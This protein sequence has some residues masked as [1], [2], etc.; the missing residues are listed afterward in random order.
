MIATAYKFIRYDKPK[1]IGVVIGIIISTFL[2]GQQVGILTFLTTLMG[3]LVSNSDTGKA[4][5]WITD[6]ITINANELAK[7]DG[8]VAREVRSIEGVE[9]AYPI[10]VTP[11]V[12]S[13]SNGKTAPVTII[14]SEAPGFVAG[15][16]KDKIIKGSLAD[17]LDDFAVSADFYDASTLTNSTDV[18]TEL[19]INGKRAIIKVQT[20]DARG[21]GGSF[22]YTTLSRARFYGNFPDDKVSA[23]AVKVK[24]G[25]PVEKVRDEINSLLPLVNAWK[26]EDLKSS[27][28]RFIVISSNIGSSIGSLVIFAIISGFFIIGLTLYSS[29]MDRVKDYGTLKAIGATNGYITRL[30]IVQSL[31]FAV[32]GFILAWML[33]EGFRAGVKNAGLIINISPL[34]LG[35]LFMITFL[36]SVGSALFFSVRTINSVEP[37]SVFRN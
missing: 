28:V 21:F 27:T 6:K 4:D 16:L 37:A 32:T 18:G 17:L 2:I 7:I 33:L 9:S 29:A 3:G 26:T 34:L 12:A 1:S 36:I 23:V 22:F 19:E 30:I 5:I 15:P 13:F 31:I 10:V 35:G 20:K 11:A 24:E 25:Y 8:S 14:G